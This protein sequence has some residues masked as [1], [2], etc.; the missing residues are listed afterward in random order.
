MHVRPVFQYDTANT[1]SCF[2]V[3]VNPTRAA[4]LS[5]PQRFF[6]M[7][8]KQRVGVHVTI[9]PIVLL[10]EELRRAR[11]A[12][13][14]AVSSGERAPDAANTSRQFWALAVDELTWRICQTKPQSA[15]GA[16]ELLT[17]IQRHLPRSH[18]HYGVYFAEVAAR[19]GEGRRMLAD[20]V[21][22]RDIQSDFE[23]VPCGKHRDDIASLIKSALFG[24][25]RPVIVF[26][27]AYGDH[28][29]GENR[30]ARTGG[31][32]T[33]SLFPRPS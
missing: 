16:A 27:R 30:P 19:F 24:A 8:F 13:S 3:W 4:F 21:W 6:F 18:T 20:F 9:D 1:P 31:R 12:L 32:V 25:T 22:L 2:M 29:E 11:A 33:R 5:L 23:C 17:I 10:A 7:L 28:S 14:Q 26:R 15:M